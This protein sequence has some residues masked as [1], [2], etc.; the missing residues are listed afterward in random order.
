MMPFKKHEKQKENRGETVNT[1]K[2]CA[3][4][5]PNVI[6]QITPDDYQ[7]CRVEPPKILGSSPFGFWPVVNEKEWCAKHKLVKKVE[8][9]P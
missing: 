1:C 6:E 4:W 8:V 7:T 2:N 5:F 3:Y 9:K